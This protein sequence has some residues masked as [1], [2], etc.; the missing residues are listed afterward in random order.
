MD[1][2]IIGQT[3]PAVEFTLKKG[4]SLYTQS[5]A[6]TWMTSGISSETS[7]KG[8]IMK[9]LG[10]V[11]SGES[12]FM[13]TYTATEDNQKIAFGSTVPGGI[14]DLKLTPD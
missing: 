9:G 11:F 10:R 12:L 3:V 6:M 8:G 7:T 4:D 1:Y 13:N 14:L 2:K 5:G